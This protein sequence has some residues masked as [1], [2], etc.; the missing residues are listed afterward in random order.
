M[1]AARRE[2]LVGP[3]GETFAELYLA[4]LGLQR[5][6]VAITNAVPLLLTDGAEVRE[7]TPDEVDEWSDWLQQEL[8]RIAPRLVV[9]LGSVAATALGELAD[10]KLPHPASVRRFGDTGEVKRKLRRVRE[11]LENVQKQRP[12]GLEEGSENTRGAAANRE[13][14][15]RW[16]EL[17]PKSGKGRFVYQHHWRGLS[18]DETRLSDSSLLD[19][20]RSLHGDLRLE[21]DGGLWGWAV[22]IGSAADN[23]R[24]GGDKLLTMKPGDQRKLR[25]QA[26]LQQP[27][28]WL[29]VGTSKPHVIESGGPGATAEKAAK[30]FAIDSGTYRLGV[31][32]RSSAE[33]FLDGGRL[34]GRYIIQL[35]EADDDGD[36]R[37]FWLIDKPEDQQPIAERRD[38]ADLIGELKQKGQKFLVWA[39]PGERPEKIDVRT[40]KVVK[41]EQ[42][43]E[44]SKADPVKRIVYGV[45]LDPYG[46]DGPQEDAHL[47]WNPPAEIEKT[48]HAFAKGDRK[49]KLQHDGPANA[50]VVETWVEQYPNRGEYLKAMRGEPHRVHRRKFGSDALH[51]G[52]WVLGV[53][54]GEKEWQAYE[55]GEINAFSPGGHGIRRPI[56][57]SQMPNV[58]F[59]DLVEQPAA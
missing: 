36:R 44:I 4:P 1:D 19:T 40:G 24:A 16:H 54:L 13:W 38:R 3:V 35:A 48:A 47:D 12:R 8:D 17:L 23:R 41:A 46:R 56:A 30:I 25:L 9:A 22:L 53:E 51:S 39:K 57:R 49:I 29:D 42:W 58:T 50:T 55:A 18:E 20:D 21:G 26:K 28:G 5:Q 2:P 32:R 59:I 10:A 31:V 52:A 34:K 15:D 33:I 7:P 37:R 11:A 43:I 27:T 14:A 45:V 6:E